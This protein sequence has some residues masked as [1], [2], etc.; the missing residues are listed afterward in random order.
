MH[1]I[2][3]YTW[4]RNTLEKITTNPI[5]RIRELLPQ[6]KKN[7]FL[8]KKMYFFGGLQKRK[9]LIIYFCGGGAMVGVILWLYFVTSI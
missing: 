6:A 8:H 5:N 4:L 9:R 2:D 3:P 7:N 1:G